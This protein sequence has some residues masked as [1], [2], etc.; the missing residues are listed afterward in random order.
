MLIIMV[1]LPRSYF[2]IGTRSHQLK[3]L[4]L[5]FVDTL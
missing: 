2:R 4:T 1:P 5:P 3:R